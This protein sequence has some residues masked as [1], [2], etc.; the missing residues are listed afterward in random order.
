MTSLDSDA[1]IIMFDLTS[2]ISLRNVP[3]WHKDLS[4][5]TSA[6]PVVLVGSKADD[7]DRKV[8]GDDL[9][10]PKEHNLP[11]FAI[12]SQTCENIEKP[13]L[14]LLKD[15]VGDPNLTLEPFPQDFEPY[16][17]Y[18]R[19]E[20]TPGDPRPK[21]S[22]TTGRPTRSPAE[23]RLRRTSSSGGARAH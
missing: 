13:I 7:P 8:N 3:K 15:L 2:R 17:R 10:Y 4:R 20:V 12:S 21:E 9:R 1:A 23:G 6:I 5:I 14:R 18:S 19:E 11:Y 22:S 16:I